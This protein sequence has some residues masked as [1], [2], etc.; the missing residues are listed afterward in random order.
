MKIGFIGF[1]EAAYHITRGLLTEGIKD[2][3]AFDIN[4]DHPSLGFVIK[5]R[6]EELGI[7]LDKSLENLIKNSDVVICATS[8]KYAIKIAKEAAEFLTNSMIYVDMNATSPMVQKEIEEITQDRC[9]FVD[10]AVVESIPTFQHKVPILVSGSGA[11]EFIEISKKYGM[12]VLK[13]SDEAGSASAIKVARSTFMKGL[14]TLLIESLVISKKYNVDNFIMESLNNTLT[15][16][17]LTITAKNLLTRTALHAERRVAEM[18][19]VI[20]TLEESDVN[21]LMSH[22]TKAKLSYIAEMKLN[23]HFNF[24]EPKDYGD[25]VEAIIKLDK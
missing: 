4:V 11:D 3:R 18:D 10:A 6:V 5:N 22:A 8:A 7:T 25:V 9:K 2:I 19:D 24:E 12:D 14:T 21:A 13:I 15:G 23:E 16:K 1:G 20:K 17:H